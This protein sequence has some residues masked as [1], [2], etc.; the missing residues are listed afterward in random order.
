M[1]IS[2][3]EEAS[4]LLKVHIFY[5]TNLA[6]RPS[7]TTDRMRTKKTSNSL[8]IDIIPSSRKETSFFSYFSP[9]QPHLAVLVRHRLQAIEASQVISMSKIS[10]NN[11]PKMV[12][13]ESSRAK[14]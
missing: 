9:N 4:I 14:I 8:P 12:E 13:L 5:P 1:K 10:T 6:R 2:W 7:A 11:R 3:L